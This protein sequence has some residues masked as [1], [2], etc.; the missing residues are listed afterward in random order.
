MGGSGDAPTRQDEGRP[1]APERYH[2]VDALRALAMFLGVVLHAALGYMVQ[3]NPF[4]PRMDPSRSAAF[5]V[6]VSLIH[7]FRMQLFFLVAGVFTA[8]LLSRRSLGAFAFGRLRRIGQPLGAGALIIVPLV[9]IPFFLAIPPEYLP[10]DWW[11]GLWGGPG[12]LWFLVYLLAFSAAACALV[13]VGR[14]TG[15]GL[16]RGLDALGACAA[17]PW[18]L[19]LMLVP[20]VLLTRLMSSWVIETP[21][22]WTLTHPSLAYYAFFFLVGCGVQSSGATMRLGSSWKW[23]LPLTAVVFAPLMLSADNWAPAAR[24][25]VSAEDQWRVTGAAAVQGLYAWGMIYGLFGLFGTLTSGRPEGRPWVRWLADSSYWVYLVHLPAVYWLQLWWSRV[26][27]PGME[28]GAAEAF[29]KFGAM[30]AA[31]T[32]FCLITYAVI[33]RPTFLEAI[34]GG[35]NKKRAREGASG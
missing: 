34:V 32:A 26:N 27:V 19:L 3:S 25:I 7:G 12:H 21:L 11:R 9:A 17:S 24:P 13:V 29:V 14:W 4:T 35:G 20:T 28:H 15:P 22:G 18:G 5:D 31:V 16:R 1:D 23:V 30:M 33:V 8:M 6:G 10:K 2:A